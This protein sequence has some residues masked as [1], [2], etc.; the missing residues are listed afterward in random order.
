VSWCLD[1]KS[2]VSYHYI[3]DPRDGSRVQLV[4]DSRRAWHA[5]KSVWQGQRDLNTH[6][7]GI[8]FAGDTHKRFPPSAEIDSVAHKCLYLMDKFNIPKANILTHEMIAPTRKNDCS[9][10]T[11]RRVLERVAYLLK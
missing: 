7:I 5:G 4:W 3:I 9:E 8:A 10:E 1:T 11:Y 6:S 2:R